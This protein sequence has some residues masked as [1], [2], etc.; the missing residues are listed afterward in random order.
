VESWAIASGDRHYLALQNDG[1]VGSHG[2]SVT[3]ARRTFRQAC[4]NVVANHS[5]TS[6]CLALAPNAPPQS[7]ASDHH[8]NDDRIASCRRRASTQ[9]RCRCSSSDVLAGCWGALSVHPGGRGEAI[10]MTETL[11][12]DPQG[13]VIFAPAPD[14]FGVPYTSFSVVANDGQ[15]DSTPERLR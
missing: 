10:T 2:V 9:R 12:S 8:G 5:A 3:T 7:P 13:R 1:S 11:V 6:S 14:E 4:G 15:Y